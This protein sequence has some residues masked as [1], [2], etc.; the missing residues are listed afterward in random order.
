MRI[1]LFLLCGRFAPKSPNLAAIQ[2]FPAKFL[3]RQP[4]NGFSAA[5]YSTMGV[6]KDLIITK[7][8]AQRL[9]EVSEWVDGLVS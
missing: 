8:C 9:K 4:K 5:L 3:Q 6:A 7:R 1:H 2:R